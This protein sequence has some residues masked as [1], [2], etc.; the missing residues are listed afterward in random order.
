MH[1]R[2]T[3]ILLGDTE[4]AAV[5]KIQARLDYAQSKKRKRVQGVHG[6]HICVSL[7]T[8]CPG[9]CGA[10]QGV[11]WKGLIDELIDLSKKK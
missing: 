9:D 3:S 11:A 4:D 5:S 2:C 1:G 8:K 10:P 7:L 6:V